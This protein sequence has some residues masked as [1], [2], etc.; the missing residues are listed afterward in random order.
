VLLAGAWWSGMW[1]YQNLSV[2]AGPRKAEVAAPGS[3]AANAPTAI[4]HLKFR[5]PKLPKNPT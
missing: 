5:A 4:A 3:E 2:V 1:T